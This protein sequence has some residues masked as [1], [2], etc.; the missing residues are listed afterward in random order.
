MRRIPRLGFASI[1]GAALA[2]ALLAAC[3]SGSTT[4]ATKAK[5]SPSTAATTSTTASS[6]GNPNAPEAPVA[7]DIPDNQ[8]F[9]AFNGGGY[10]IKVPEGWARSSAGGAVVFSD[11]YNAIRIETRASSAAPTVASVGS[12]DVPALRAS[13]SGFTL[14]KVTTVSRAAGPA[15]LVTYQAESAADPVT[16][17]KV[18]LDVERYGFWKNGSTTTITLSAP[19]GSDNVDPW[20]IITNSFAWPA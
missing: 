4:K 2:L 15:V 11:R 13:N 17:K 3:A 9:V 12:T 10:T 19:R 16:S 6:V 8:A 5:P 14:G 18:L 1:T 20:K 7:G